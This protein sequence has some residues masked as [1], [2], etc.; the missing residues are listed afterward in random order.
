MTS[1]SPQWAA[2]KAPQAAPG[3]EQGGRAGPLCPLA[4]F[5]HSLLA[6]HSPRAKSCPPS[7]VSYVWRVDSGTCWDNELEASAP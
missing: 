2:V 7:P 5:T 4:S 6:P 1:V 3:E